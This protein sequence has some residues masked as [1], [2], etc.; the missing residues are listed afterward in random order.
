M[1]ALMRLSTAG[2]VLAVASLAVSSRAFADA[3][4]DQCVDANS[5]AQLSRRSGK[6]QAAREEL[7][8]CAESRCPSM[9][10]DDCAQRLDEVNRIQPTIVFDGKDGRGN[11]VI[12]AAVTV[13]GHPL[14]DKLD[15]SPLNVDPGPHTFEFVVAGQP[16]VERSFVLKEG[17]KG[18][19]ERIAFGPAPAPVPLPAVAAPPAPESPPPPAVESSGHGLGAAKVS[20]IVIAALGLGGIA[21]GAA[22]GLLAESAWSRSKSECGAADCPAS[23][24]PQAVSNRQTA[25]TDGTVST[26]GF[27]AGGALFVGGI[28]IALA[29]PSPGA[30]APGAALRVAPTFGPGAAG[31]DLRGEF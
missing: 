23:T 10:R 22:Y 5:K 12:A 9:V 18:R 31:L 24:R 29:S 13:D 21:A 11:D 1:R 27:I 6:L 26:V 20:G 17:E 4:S 14:A 19:V 2:L 7:R 8:S 28:T 25:V 15:G 30:H 16:P 3:T